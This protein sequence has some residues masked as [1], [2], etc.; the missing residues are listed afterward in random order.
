MIILCLIITL[1]Y[2][3]TLLVQNMVLDKTT[4]RFSIEI[5]I[6]KQK[7]KELEQKCGK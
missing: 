1:I 4:E 6:L 5:E 3:F 7:V 2:V